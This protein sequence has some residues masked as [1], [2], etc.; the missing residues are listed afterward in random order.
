MSTAENIQTLTGTAGSAVP[1]YRFVKLAAD[2]KFDLQATADARVDGVSA[3]A[4]S[5]DTKLFAVAPVSQPGVMKVEASAAIS[6]GDLVAATVT[7]GKAKT[8]ASAGAATYVVGVAK[9]AATA[10]GDIIEV[11]L[12]PFK[13]AAS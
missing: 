3:E 1:I 13:N 9:T 5:A 12:N 7:T 11:W 8:A 2:G 4:A 10:D 6:V